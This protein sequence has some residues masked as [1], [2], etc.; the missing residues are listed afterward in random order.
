[1]T[2]QPIDEQKLEAKAMEAF[3]LLN[4]LSAAVGVHYGMQLGLFDA[5]R[6]AEPSTSAE[7]ASRLGLHE[8][9]V[10]EWLYQQ[11][12][13]GVL[14]HENGERF[15]LSPEGALIFADDSTPVSLAGLFDALPS[16]LDALSHIPEGMRSGVGQPYDAHGASGAAL[17]EQGFKGTITQLTEEGLPALE[18]V[19]EKL[20]A[21]G[22][23]AA[24]V[25]CGG[26]LRTLAMAQAFPASTW[27]GYDNSAHALARAERNLADCG[28]TNCHFVNSDTTPL[29]ADHS[30]DLVTFCDVV[31]DL[32]HPQEMLNAVYQALKPDGTVLVIDIAQPESISDRLAHPAAAAMYGFSM[33]FCMSSGLSAEGGA[34]LGPFG[35]PA[36][37]LQAMAEAAG[38]TRFRVTDVPDPFNAYYEIRP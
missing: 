5:L 11:A 10:R 20:R 23:R 29:P 37:K 8:R 3:G 6:G 36:S 12:A 17:V 4:G 28:A 21:G 34:G 35:M 7:L 22:A 14:E 30:L 25:G 33:G 27:T 32:S 13:A 26:G 9:W 24:D 38:F 15:W 18:G 1:M 19:A 16:F 31:H 2:T